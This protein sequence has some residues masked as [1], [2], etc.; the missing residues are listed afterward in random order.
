MNSFAARLRAA[1]ESSWETPSSP[2]S[3][4]GTRIRLRR[5]R[6]DVVGVE[7]NLIVYF[8]FLGVAENVVG[9][10]ERL[11]LL[12]SRLVA[13]IDVGMVLPRQFAKGLANLV[14]RGGL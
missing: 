10:G 3:S 6:I 13:G 4:A 14:R 8:A 9:L 11:E 1:R 12:L 2:S 5:G 7:P